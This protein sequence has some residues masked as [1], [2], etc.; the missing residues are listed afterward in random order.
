MDRDPQFTSG[1]STKQITNML[2]KQITAGQLMNRERIT[3]QIYD[4]MTTM[5]FIWALQQDT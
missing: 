3:M 1:V 2:G 5:I 4:M